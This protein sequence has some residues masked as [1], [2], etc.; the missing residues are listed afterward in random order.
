MFLERLACHHSRHKHYIIMTRFEWDKSLLIVVYGLEAKR[1]PPRDESTAT[2][3]FR[4]SNGLY[5]EPPPPPP[6]FTTSQ[7]PTENP[8]SLEGALERADVAGNI[9]CD[10]QGLKSGDGF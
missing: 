2:N 8:R 6:P 5:S 3:R 4:Y 1:S 10:T 7:V 9:T